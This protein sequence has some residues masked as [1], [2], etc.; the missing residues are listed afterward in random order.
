MDTNQEQSNAGPV[1]D[2]PDIE[3]HPALRK[4]GA[5]DPSATST[6][7]TIKEGDNNE[8]DYRTMS[9]WRA[10]SLM[11]AETISLGILSLPKAVATVGLMPGIILIL[12]IG[13]L[14]SYGGYV[15][16]MMKMKYPNIFSFADAF[17]LMA[18]FGRPQLGRWFAE[19]M[20]DVLIVFVMAAHVLT[21]TVMMNTLTGHATC[22][23][24]WAIV[25]AVL[26]LILTLPRTYK[27][28]GLISMFSCASICAAVFIAMIGIG[29][30]NEPQRIFAVTP[31]DITTYHAGAMVTAEIVT[32]FTG[33][34]AFFGFIDEMKKPGDFPKALALL[35][36][37]ALTFY[38]V[39][40][41][42]IYT[43]IGQDVKAPAIGSANPVVRKVAY[44]IACPT[45]VIA[46]VIN[47]VIASKNIYKIVWR[48]NP[49]VM[50]EKSWRARSSWWAII[51][52]LWVIAFV[53]AEAIPIFGNL[54]G[55]LG[56]A[57]CVWFT[58]GFPALFWLWMNKDQ[59]RQK[60]LLTIMN[61][62]VIAISLAICIVGLWGSGVQIGLDAKESG[63]PFS[64]KDN[65]L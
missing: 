49:D 5:V 19:V 33:S 56:A 26:S 13:A 32:A 27:S 42:V 57:L 17:E 65:S 47:A 53:I 34:I 36:T 18:P 46:G 2:R 44:G 11:I 55:I 40:A 16:Y 37:C 23:V 54:L 61:W 7:A 9:W 43:Y 38:L 64:C 14:A 45:I 15:I 63:T 51:A 22:T 12:F 58:V 29:T 31:A 4:D 41:I 52:I 25:G 39:V 1:S 50:K 10:A 62:A 30:V 48:S 35:Q 8:V 60:L 24:H 28:H 3:K 6:N 59:L 21:F 20:Q